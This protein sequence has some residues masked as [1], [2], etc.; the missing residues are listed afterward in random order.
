MILR[1]KKKTCHILYEMELDLWEKRF[2]L[3]VY[4][5][6][7][8]NTGRLYVGYDS[9]NR[10]IHEY[11]GSGLL[12]KQAII[13]HRIENFKKTVLAHYSTNKEMWKGERYWIKKLNS[14]APKGY[15]VMHSYDIL[16]NINTCLS[17]AS[18]LVKF[19]HEGLSVR[20]EAFL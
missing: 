13:K 1:R 10:S 9:F 20:K 18:S 7:Y 8:L 19:S 17:Q 3:N 5:I 16:R 14:L 12:I 15:N 2:D 4:K 11:A 6:E